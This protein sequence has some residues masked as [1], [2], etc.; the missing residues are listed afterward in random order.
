ML[1]CIK[2]RAKGGQLWVGTQVDIEHVGIVWFRM[3]IVD[4]L[5]HDLSLAGFFVI[6]NLFERQ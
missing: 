6:G 5:L 3:R 4:F 1:E 2:V